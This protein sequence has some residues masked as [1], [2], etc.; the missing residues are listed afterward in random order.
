MLNKVTE[1]AVSSLEGTFSITDLLR[2]LG[3][4]TKGWGLVWK[5]YTPVVLKGKRWNTVSILKSVRLR[6]IFG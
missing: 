1:A 6:R 5:S 3:R 2:M 4:T